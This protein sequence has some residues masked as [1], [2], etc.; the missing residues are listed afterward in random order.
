[1]R[2][3]A[4]VTKG[5]EQVAQREIEK[6]VPDVSGIEV[7]NKR[8]MFDTDS[9][10]EKLTSLR[11]V[12][13]MCLLLREMSGLGGMDDVLTELDSADLH[14]ARG[15]VSRLRELDDRF[16]VTP[17]VL[18][19]KAVTPQEIAALV[20]GRIEE[21]YRWRFDA[22]DHSVFD[23]RLFIEGA[24]GYVAVRL[25]ERSLMHRTYKIE[26][27]PGSLRPTVAAAMVLMASSFS[28]SLRVVDNF[29]GSGTILCEALIAGHQVSGGDIDRESVEITKS[30]LSRLRHRAPD[31][32]RVLDAVKSPW[33]ERHF[34]LAVSNLPWG[35]QVE[36]SSVTS[37]Y[38]KALREYRRIVKQT[39]AVCMLVTKPELLVKY[40]R[41]HFAGAR[42]ETR[43]LGFTGQ[44]PSIILIRQD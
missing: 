11:T 3:I 37:L 6:T 36:L 29:C 13:D 34:D 8:V 21:K 31:D 16:S 30:N 20:A 4:F 43:R 1:M 23:I 28:T 10:P 12:D 44:T 26:S 22:T 15:A 27:K 33:R 32:V 41:K 5:L 38:D 2:Y 7:G 14:A 19:M 17:T 25:T 42:I 40:A 24:V 35:K 39:G 9:A 18:G